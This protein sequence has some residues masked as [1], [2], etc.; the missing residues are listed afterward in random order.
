MAAPATPPRTRCASRSP[1]PGAT[2][3]SHPRTSAG[4]STANP[5]SSVYS[6]NGTVTASSSGLDD[7]HLNHRHRPDHLPNH[8]F[9]NSM[10][11]PPTDNRLDLQWAIGECISYDNV[12]PISPK[13]VE[14]YRQFIAFRDSRSKYLFCYPVK[15]CNKDTFLYYLQ[16]VLRFFTTRGFKPRVLRSDYYTTFR[17]TKANQ[18]YED[19]QCRHESSAPYQ[20]WQNA[21]ERDIQTILSNVSATIHGQDFLRADIWAHALTHWTRLHNLLRLTRSTQGHPRPDNKPRVLRR[22]TSPISLRG[23]AMLPP[24]R[25]RAPM[26]IRCQERHRLLRRRRRQLQRWIRDLHALHAQLPHPW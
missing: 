1:P 25:P 20:Q 11:F 16:C 13:S 5:A 26:E 19:D 24:P 10:D 18:F 21:V 14:G 4:S 22:R 3:T 17:S 2:P 9:T 8:P 15:T 7:H 6:P 12:G 23:F